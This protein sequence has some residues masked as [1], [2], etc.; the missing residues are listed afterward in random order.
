MLGKV[1][2]IIVETRHMDAAQADPC[3]L[4]IDAEGL[5]LFVLPIGAAR[6]DELINRIGDTRG[7]DKA[8]IKR[9]MRSKRNARFTVWQH[10]RIADNSPA[11]QTP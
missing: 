11:G 7:F 4:L 10:D 2:K 5:I 8:A 3:W 9:A 6:S 1:A